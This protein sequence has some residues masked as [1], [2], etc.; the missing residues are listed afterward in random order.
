MRL[1][2]E[3]AYGP[4]YFNRIRPGPAEYCHHYGCARL[5]RQVPRPEPDVHSL[6]FQSL[7]GRSD[8]LQINRRAIALS[9][10][11]VVVVVGREQLSLRLQQIGAMRA[12]ELI[13]TRVGRPVLDRR[14]EIVEGDV[15]NGHT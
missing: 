12:I 11:Q 1:D 7:P 4:R 3:V 14:R 6:I 8:I 9:D 5:L 13:S 2:G 15:A 10:D